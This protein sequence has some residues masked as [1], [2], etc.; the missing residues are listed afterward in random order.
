[1]TTCYEVFVAK[2]FRSPTYW[3]FDFSLQMYGAL[4][5]MAGAYTLSTEA[6]V[7]GDV[8]YRYFPIRVQAWIDLILYFIFFF[9]GILALAVVGMD[10][11]GAAWHAKETSWNSPAEIQ[12]YGIKTLIPVA[13]WLLFLQ[14]I[15]E[16]FRC[17]ICIKTGHWPAR[18]VVAEEMEAVLTRSS[19]KQDITDVI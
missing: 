18:S 5:I 4:F 2:V 17:M 8:I 6:H 12:I 10:Y 15:S 14:G 9:P 7:R 1:L 3:A 11:A 19:K 13:G 16:V